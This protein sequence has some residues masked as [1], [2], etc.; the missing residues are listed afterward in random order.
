MVD[1]GTKLANGRAFI[2][3]EPGGTPDG[4][5]CDVDGN[6]WCGWGMGNEKQDGVKVFN[7][8]GKPIGLIALPE[9]C[10]NVCFGGVEAQ[11]PVHGGEPLGLFAL[12]EHA[13]RA[14]RVSPAFAVMSALGHKRTF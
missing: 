2:T 14:G 7:P 9:R 12:R 8:D 10:A 1:D 6:L 4:F 5:R 13:G 11:P 3:A